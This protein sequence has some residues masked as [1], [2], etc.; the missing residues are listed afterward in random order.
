MAYFYKEAFIEIVGYT[1][2][3]EFKFLSVDEREIVLGQV[4]CQLPD[5]G[6]QFFAGI[7]RHS[8]IFRKNSGRSAK[9]SL[10]GLSR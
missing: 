6:F 1:V 9:G 10:L 7:R 8:I 2:A 3:P 4:S 5:F